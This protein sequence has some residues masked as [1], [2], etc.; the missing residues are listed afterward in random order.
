MTRRSNSDER[1]TVD[2]LKR[3]KA[4]RVAYK[5]ADFLASDYARPARLQLELLKTEIGMR[6]N[7]IKSTIVVF[8]GTRILE[9]AV[10]ARNVRRAQARLKKNP[11]DPTLKRD[12]QIARS[13]NEKSVY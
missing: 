6:Q 1:R 12:L 8:G 2:R 11:G 10:A 3:S 7:Q 13:L 9:P 4:Y 5:D